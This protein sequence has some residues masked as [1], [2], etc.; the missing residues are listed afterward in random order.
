MDH[1]QWTDQYNPTSS[2]RWCKSVQPEV[3][4]FMFYLPNFWSCT[5][6]SFELWAD[7][8][9]CTAHL[10]WYIMMLHCCGDGDDP[11]WLS[12]IHLSTI[13][14]YHRRSWDILIKFGA[15]IINL[16]LFHTIQWWTIVIMSCERTNHHEASCQFWNIWWESKF[17]ELIWGHNL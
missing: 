7:L 13:F 1:H 9:V 15:V 5:V 3:D 2:I 17:G 16:E 4:F 14:D 11:Q 6:I 10:P 8:L 12:I